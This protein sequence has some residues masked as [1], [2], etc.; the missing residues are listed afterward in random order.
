MYPVI[1]Y[2]ELKYKSVAALTTDTTGGI[3]IPNGEVIALHRL[4]AAG[5]DPDVYVLLAW[6][7]GGGSE[8]IFASTRGDIDTLFDTSQ[9]A[10]QVTGD[11]SKKIKIVI[12][13]DSLLASPI[14][15]GSIELVKVG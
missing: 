4:R 7:W 14:V 3:T 2:S 8:K 15:G 13:N 1:A 10:N 12:V 5:V 6:D 11:G 9:A